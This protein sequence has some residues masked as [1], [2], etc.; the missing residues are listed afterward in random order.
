MDQD[1]MIDA[2][3]KHLSALQY[4]VGWALII[5]FGVGWAGL[6]NKKEIELVRL[7]FERRTAFYV[8]TLLYLMANLAVLLLLWRIKALLTALPD[9]HFVKGYTTLALHDWLLNP[10]AYVGR[11]TTA[12]LSTM[13]SMG[14][15]IVSWW[16][17]ITSVVVLRGK[18]PILK[19]VILP[20]LFYGAGTASLV[21]LYQ[22][23]RLNRSRLA[24]LDQTL[25][26]DLQ[27]TANGRWVAIWSGFITGMAIFSVALWFQRRGRPK[28][29][30]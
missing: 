25:Y 8:A 1:L 26:A 3:G 20:V 29:A 30:A 14:L 11:G 4:I 28:S 13:W 22:I 9:E 10:F 17:C 16:I 7:K 12:E 5:A 24:I 21:C 19:S 2:L 23:Y 27:A 6:Q 15:W 18:Q